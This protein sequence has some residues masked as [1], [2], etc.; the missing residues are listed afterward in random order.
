M[1]PDAKSF[2]QEWIE[3][4]NS[5]DLDRI[6]DHYS[7]DISVTTPMIKVALGIDDGTLYGKENVR[8]YW[9]TALQKSSDLHF[10]LFETTESIDS[11]ALFYK[12]VMN[13]MAIE[14]M[15][16]DGNGKVNRMIAHYN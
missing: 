4:W 8:Q 13:K 10:E 6:L 7:D 5:H 2:A 11:I 9:R 14:V 15:F 12:S 1:K 3:S 16:F